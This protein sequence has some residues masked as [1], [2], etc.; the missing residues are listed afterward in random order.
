MGKASAREILILELTNRFRLNPDEEFDAI[1][2]NKRRQEARDD[3]TTDALRFFDVNLNKL[4]RELDRVDPAQPLAWSSRLNAAATEHARAL[5]RADAQAHQL[6]GGP[7]IRERIEDRN[8]SPL[9]WAENVYSYADNPV[10]A[11]DGMIVDWGPGPDG[12]QADR[13]HRVNAAFDTFRQTGVAFLREGDAD[14]RVGPFV[15]VQKFATETTDAPFLTG[16]VYRDRDGDDFYSPGEGRKGAV[17]RVRGEGAER[18]ERAGDWKHEVGEGEHMLVIRGKGVDG[19][20]KGRVTVERDNVKIDVVDGDELHVSGDI[21]LIRA[22]RKVFALGGQGLEIA[23]ARG[24]DRLFGS[25][26]ADTLDGERGADLLRG[27]DGADA[28]RGGGGRDRLF[29]Q[30]GRDTLEGGGGDDRLVGG[31]GSDLFRFGANDGE[32]VIRGWRD[33]ADRLDL[34]PAGVTGFA[35]LSVSAA[36][37]DAVLAFAGTTVTIRGA[38]GEIDPSDILFA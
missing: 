7:T 38:A 13:G 3:D 32:D 22:P 18:S 34:A 35:Q 24:R 8:F 1:I 30:R 23:G 20:I 28:L 27:G 31:G 12:M 2:R 25:D 6:P 9:G 37:G 4:E 11:H 33:G 14:T 17:F 36:G 16:V 15:M 26:G 5:I 21:D 29:G 10:F 19:R